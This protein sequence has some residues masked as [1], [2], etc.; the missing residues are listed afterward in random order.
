MVP[1]IDPTPQLCWLEERFGRYRRWHRGHA[2]LEFGLEA[3]MRMERHRTTWMLLE[4][5]DVL[6]AD[7]K[8]GNGT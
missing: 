7:P 3:A 1:T 8:E 4:H 5:T 2:A 6:H